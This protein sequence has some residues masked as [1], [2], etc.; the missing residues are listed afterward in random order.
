MILKFLVSGSRQRTIG[1]L[2]PSPD[3]RLRRLLTFFHSFHSQTTHTPT[4][5]EP[6]E[7]QCQ[8][9]G[10]SWGPTLAWTRSQYSQSLLCRPN[11]LCSI[12]HTA[13]IQP[14][15]PCPI[16]SAHSVCC[17]NHCRTGTIL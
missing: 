4:P 7:S 9:Y 6:V 13:W 12:C 10:K 16:R 11:Y 2:M 17:S 3:L 15:I 1:L 5:V 14:R 8:N